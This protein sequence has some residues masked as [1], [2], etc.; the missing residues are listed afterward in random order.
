[1]SWTGAFAPFYVF[2][3]LMMVPLLPRIGWGWARPCEVGVRLFLLAWVVSGSHQRNPSC[4]SLHP[5]C[6]R[7]TNAGF[8]SSDADCDGISQCAPGKRSRDVPSCHVTAS[9]LQFVSI[10]HFF[11]L[12]HW[13]RD[14]M[15]PW[16]GCLLTSPLLLPQC[17]PS[18]LLSAVNSIASPPPTVLPPVFVPVTVRGKGIL[19]V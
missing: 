8:W 2:C 7:Y 18:L 12:C 9:F 6:C 15:P 17:H 11:C 16:L 13:A 19:A 5:C 10:P 4:E 14:I 3:G 1:M